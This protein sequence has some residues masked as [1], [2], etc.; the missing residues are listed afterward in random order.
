MGFD[1]TALVM[2]VLASE[3]LCVARLYARFVQG[4]GRWRH[5]LEIGVLKVE[6]FFVYR[7]DAACRSATTWPQPSLATVGGG[8]IG[9]GI[10]RQNTSPPTYRAS[11]FLPNL[12]LV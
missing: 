2:R 3:C 8:R 11:V 9:R 1:T 12:F 7:F 6:G 10:L 5:V 4:F